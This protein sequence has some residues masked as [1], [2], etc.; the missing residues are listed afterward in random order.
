MRASVIKLLQDLETNHIEFFPTR[1]ATWEQWKH[2]QGLDT[3][4]SF[5]LVNFCSLLEKHTVGGERFAHFLVS[6][7]NFV[8]SIAVG[9][10]STERSNAIWMK[11]TEQAGSCSEDDRSPLVHSIAKCLYIFLQKQVSCN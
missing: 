1:K 5:L 2:S 6:W 4:L 8:G 3:L 7:Y 10:L 9:S 11:L